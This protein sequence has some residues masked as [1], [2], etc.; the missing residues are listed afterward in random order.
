MGTLIVV[1]FSLLVGAVTYAA[2]IRGG[3]RAPVAVGFDTATSAATAYDVPAVDEEPETDQE[4]TDP[5]PGEGEVVELDEAREARPPTD[6]EVTGEEAH[7]VATPRIETRRDAETTIADPTDP[8]YTY[9]RVATKGPSWRDRIA[10]I[11][12]IIVLLAVSAGVLAFGV[13]QL[14]HVINATVER[15]FGN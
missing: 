13:Y 11:A 7:A 9:L 10:G 12:M 1:I 6:R 14:G 3:R 4:T 5:E 15:F 8:D 2:T